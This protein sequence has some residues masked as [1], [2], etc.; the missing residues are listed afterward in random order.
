LGQGLAEI[1]LR[2]KGMELKKIRLQILELGTFGHILVTAFIQK[3]SR[4][5]S[6]S[7]CVTVVWLIRDWIQ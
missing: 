5:R 3:K 6:V 1:F 2:L 7:F 4:N